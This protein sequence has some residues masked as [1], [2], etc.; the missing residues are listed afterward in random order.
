MRPIEST[1]L[2]LLRY[3]RR[4]SLRESLLKSELLNFFLK[5]FELVGDS[6]ARG[7]FEMLYENKT[8]VLAGA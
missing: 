3:L 8:C 5:G 2:F 1:V 4:L 6:V 7:L